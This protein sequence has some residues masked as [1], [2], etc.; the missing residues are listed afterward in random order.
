[1]QSQQEMDQ[2]FKAL[3]WTYSQGRN[4]YFD[5]QKDFFCDNH[6]DDYIAVTSDTDQALIKHPPVACRGDTPHLLL[7]N[8]ASFIRG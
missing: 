7:A 4:I 8:S 1:M 2:N 3:Y 6:L 5:Y